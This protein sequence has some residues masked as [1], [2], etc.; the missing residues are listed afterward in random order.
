MVQERMGSPGEVRL[1]LIGCGQIGRLHAERIVADG[2]AKIVALCD[3]IAGNAAR[4]QSEFAGGARLY[5]DVGAMAAAGGANGRAGPCERYGRNI[6]NF[7]ASG[8]NGR[9]PFIFP[10]EKTSSR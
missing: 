6:Q 8:A 7:T 3:P 9:K 1:A 2:R 5:A 10:G 4:L